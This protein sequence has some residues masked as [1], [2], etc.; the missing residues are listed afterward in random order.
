MLE[1]PLAERVGFWGFPLAVLA[2]CGDTA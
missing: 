1:S 2:I